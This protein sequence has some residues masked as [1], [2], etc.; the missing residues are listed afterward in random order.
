MTATSRQAI[1]C[2]SWRRDR[3]SARAVVS[4]RRFVTAARTRTTRARFRRGSDP[5]AAAAGNIARVLERISASPQALAALAGILALLGRACG[6]VG[7]RLLTELGCGSP[8]GR[9]WCPALMATYWA[10]LVPLVHT[11]LLP[12]GWTPVP[13]VL[14]W[15][16]ALLSACDLRT[17]RLPDALTATACPALLGAVAFAAG[18]G[19][20]RAVVAGGLLGSVLFTV[21]YAAVRFVS[22]RSLGPG[23]V[24]LATSLGLPLGAVSPHTVLLVMVVA[25]AGSLAWMLCTRRRCVPHGPAMLL[26]AWSVTAMPGLFTVQ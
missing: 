3:K 1:N 18:P 9:A 22:P 17:S 14:A 4:A 5:D 19:D 2:S 21:G 25:A 10:S 24:K 16:T 8:T 13:V 20:V 11:G 23:D 7:E 6:S 12:V 26:P 15:F